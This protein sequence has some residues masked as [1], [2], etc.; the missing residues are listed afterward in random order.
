[1]MGK[2][3]L[4]GQFEYFYNKFRQIFMLVLD[5]FQVYISFHRYLNFHILKRQLLLELPFISS[6]CNGLLHLEIYKQLKRFTNVI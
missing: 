3:E 6:I 1:M 2:F 5:K 4:S